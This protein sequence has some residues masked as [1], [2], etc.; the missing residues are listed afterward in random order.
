MHYT[1]TDVIIKSDGKVGIGTV[2]PSGT[3]HVYTADAGGHIVTNASH[4]DLIIENNGS[5]GIQ[6]S[7]PASSYQYVAF[8]DTASAN[9]GYVRYYHGDNIMDLRAGGSDI[10]TLSGNKVGIGV[11][12][13]AT[14]LDVANGGVIKQEVTTYDF[15]PSA[16]IAGQ[17]AFISDSYYAFSSSYVGS[18]VANGG[19]YFSPVYSDGSYWRYG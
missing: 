19:S 15:L 5:C 3:L 8:G 11:R 10:L 2:T 7:S 16:S 13:P 18:I 9:Q 12:N 6:F 17:R 1:T 4:D 14:A